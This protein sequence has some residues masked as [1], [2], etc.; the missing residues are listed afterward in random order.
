MQHPLFPVL[1]LAL[2][3][4]LI[5]WSCKHEPIIPNLPVNPPLKGF[6]DP[7]SVYFQNQILPLL[8]SNC[9]EAGCHN[10]Q[11]HQEGIVLTTYQRL[12][13]TVTHVTQNDWEK[14]KLIKSL[15]ETDLSN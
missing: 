9:T 6:C 3:L 15:Q 13:A 1:V 14:N 2:L 5:I 11:D 10:E 8:V 4:P 7:D 12:L